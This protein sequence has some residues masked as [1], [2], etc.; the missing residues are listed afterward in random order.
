M[1]AGAGSDL[2]LELLSA[3]DVAA[4]VAGRLGGPVGAPLTAFVYARTDGNALFM[5]TIVEHLVQQRAVVQRAGQWTLREDAE[6]QVAGLP[7]GLQG[8]L[9]RRIEALPPAVRRVLEAASVVGRAFTVAAVA[10]GSQ[11]SV[12]DVE[13][14]CEG[15]AAQQHLL[16]DDGTAG[17]AGWHQW[18]P[19]PLSACPVPAGPV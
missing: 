7:E 17:M 12:E 10:A 6:A 19:L 16:D 14:V 5:V 9:R 18:G 15:L 8:L 3:A 2:R 11:A 4:Y 13:A 1:W